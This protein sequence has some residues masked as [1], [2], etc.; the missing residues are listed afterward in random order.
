M[1]LINLC[2]GGLNQAELS[3]VLQ[4]LLT[5]TPVVTTSTTLAIS[6]ISIL[7]LHNTLLAS[8]YANTLRDPPPTE[9]APWV[10]ATDKPTTTSKNAGASGA[11]DKAEERL[12]KEVMAIHPR[13]RRRI[14]TLKETNKSIHDGLADMQDYR[15]ELAVKPPDIAPQSAGGLQRTNWDIEIRRRYAQTLAEETLEFPTQND[16]QNRIEPI[17]YEE[18]LVGGCPHGSL[19]LCTEILEQSTEAFLKELLSGIYAHARSNGEGCVQTGNFKRQL[20][21]EEEDA[22]RGTLQR[23]PAGFLP[24]E[25]EMQVK[26]EGLCMEDMRLSLQVED[27][28]MKQEPFL[29]HRVLLSQYE[30]P[31]PVPLKLNGVTGRHMVNGT[32]PKTDSGGLEDAMAVDDEPTWRGATKADAFELRSVLDD[33]LAVG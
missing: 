20:R 12:K 1:L 5:L 28:Y 4:P 33:C 21:K 27:G 17:C 3:W 11:N 14:K 13:D 23:N 9:V 32:G 16:V 15:H 22:E 6:P 24:A 7:H 31:A 29:S 26:R 19:Q 25:L 10:V 18:G 2:T 8:L 30:Q